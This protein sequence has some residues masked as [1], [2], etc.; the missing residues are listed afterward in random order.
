MTSSVT[1]SNARYKKQHFKELRRELLDLM[2]PNND[3]MES[4]DQDRIKRIEDIGKIIGSPL[5]AV[6]HPIKIELTKFSHGEYQALRQIG[7]TVDEIKD[8]AGIKSS[9]AWFEW[10]V[11]R[12]FELG[13]RGRRTIE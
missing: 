7:Y 4:G 3:W 5:M 8:A 6:S 9:S 13:K 2:G 12:G 10:R 1:F 11:A